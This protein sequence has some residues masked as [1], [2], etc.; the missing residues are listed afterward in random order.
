MHKK[1]F[2]FLPPST[3][4]ETGVSSK[5][6]VVVSETGVSARLYLPEV[7]DNRKLPL[8]IYFH[9]GGFCV[10]SAFSPRYHQYLSALAALANV[11]I[12]SVEYRLAPDHRLPIPYD[13]CWDAIQWVNSHS[14][15]DGPE[16][17]LSNYANFEKVF[18]AGDSAG[19]NIAHNLAMKAGN[20]QLVG[21]VKILGVVLDQPFFLG[22]ELTSSE[23]RYPDMYAMAG[24][25][26]HYSCPSE[27]GSKDCVYINPLAVG[28]PSLSCLGCSQVLIFIAEKDSGKDRGWLYYDTLAKSKWDG[29]VEIMEAKGEEH[30]F[31][32]NR[33]TAEQAMTAMK[34]FASFLNKE[35]NSIETS[36]AGILFRPV[37]ASFQT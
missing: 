15:G 23:I 34:L 21:D 32:V 3:D 33:S 26:W 7:I 4:S 19:A 31:V 35:K 9:G 20:M 37:S 6:V 28:A 24:M 5:D 22:E 11:F 12:V 8:L 16:T 36:R 1:D 25:F 30:G 27:T 17:W 14:M 2:G 10:E 13:D 29:V 18:L